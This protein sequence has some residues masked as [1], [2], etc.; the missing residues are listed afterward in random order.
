VDLQEIGGGGGEWMELAQDR[1]R[2]RAHVGTV[3]KLRVP[4]KLGKFVVY[5]QILVSF[6]KRTLLHGVSK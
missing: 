4:K 3:K 5:L 2:W 1:D 6:S